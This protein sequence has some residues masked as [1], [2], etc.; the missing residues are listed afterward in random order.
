MLIDSKLCPHLLEVNAH[1]SLRVDFEQP[2]KP[3][4]V[5]YIPSPVDMAIKLPVVKDSLKIIAAKLKRHVYTCIIKLC[6]SYGHTPGST[7][8]FVPDTPEWLGN[9]FH[10]ASSAY[11]VNVNVVSLY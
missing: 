6:L 8:N 2:V 7:Q 3:G 5:E 11:K 1:P 10:F 4:V 9:I